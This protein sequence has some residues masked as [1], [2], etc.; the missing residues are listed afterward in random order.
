MWANKS[1]CRNRTTRL[2]LTAVVPYGK[3]FFSGLEFYLVAVHELADPYLVLVVV[4]V[5]L[6]VLVHLPFLI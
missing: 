5:K 3:T 6:D 4:D 1:T 2:T